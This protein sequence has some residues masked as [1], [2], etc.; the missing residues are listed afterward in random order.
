MGRR[1]DGF[2]LPFFFV[3]QPAAL[4]RMVIGDSLLRPCFIH[5]PEDHAL[6]LHAGGR[7]RV[8]LARK[9]GP[10]WREQS[11]SAT[12][13]GHA[14]R[15]LAAGTDLYLTQNRFFGRR[16][17]VAGLAELDALFTDL[18][19]YKTELA[20]C[21]PQHILELA[22]E[23]LARARLP[24]PSF[25]I[26][27]GRGLAFVWLHRAVPRAAL[28]RWQ[29]CQDVLYRTLRHLGADRLARD[30]ARVLRLVGTRNSRSG[31]LVEAL[32]P[33]GQVWDF[34]L[35]ADEILP[36]GRAAIVALRLERARHR[37]KGDRRVR[38]SRWF[39]AASLWE[40]RLDELQRLLQHRWFGQLPEGQRDAWMLLAGTAMSHL[41]PAPL[42]RREIVVL[43][44]QVTGGRW[45]EGETR[46]R[47]S[48][49]IR[50]AEQA[51]RGEKVEWR[52]RLVDPR[53]HFRSDTI[54]ELLAVTE[55]EMR[56]CGFRNLVSAEVRRELH[57]QGEAQR[58]R[59]AGQQ[60]RAE[61]EAR[62]LS[63]LKPWKVE[64][65]SRRSWYRKR[66]TGPCRCMVGVAP[67]AEPH[68]L[69][70]QA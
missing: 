9:D 19:Y 34:D 5:D 27:T 70:E 29:A 20:G 65:V 38:P 43:A 21:S 61:Y 37:S 45:S 50:R 49:V 57:R 23:A 53:Y 62:S 16:R 51:A 36:L 63:H 32:T 14:V 66:G 7:G 10:S 31:L 41:V 42:V 12:D 56:A 47:M 69:L 67:P 13:L 55:A 28:P 58:R 24:E 3:A 1:T 46:S 52:G 40:L 4:R 39:T 60:I 11:F 48:A 2:R 18:D 6:A 54:V 26:W 68:E 64:G 35:L 15:H 17:N 8:T 33:V 59:R 30:A 44:D 22:L 25:A